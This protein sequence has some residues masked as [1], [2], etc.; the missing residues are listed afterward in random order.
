MIK[1]KNLWF[2]TITRFNYASWGFESTTDLF[3]FLS[4]SII[5]L[6]EY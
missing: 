5:D 6:L 4:Y 1:T 2:W 3:L